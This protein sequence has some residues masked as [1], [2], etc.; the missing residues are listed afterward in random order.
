MPAP[1]VEEPLLPPVE[2]VPAP[3]ETEEKVAQ[4]D[5]F[6]HTAAENE[7]LQSIADMYETTVEDLLQLNPQIKGDSDLKPQ[8]TV[9]KVP[10]RSN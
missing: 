8:V 6:N 7:T 9:L 4:W 5:Y 2:P 10:S 3:A 1:A